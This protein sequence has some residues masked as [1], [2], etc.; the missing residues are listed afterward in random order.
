M[1][2]LLDDMKPKVYINSVIWGLVILM[3]GIGITRYNGIRGS[4]MLIVV[5]SIN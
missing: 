2:K 5:L 1:G 3:I 4:V